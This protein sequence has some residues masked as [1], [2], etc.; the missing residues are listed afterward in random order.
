MATCIQTVTDDIIDG[1]FT[2]AANISIR[3]EVFGHKQHAF[4]CAMRLVF[5]SNF[6]R[7]SLTD[8][9]IYRRNRMA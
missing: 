2:D 6:R 5:G 7:G 9:E 1:M 4:P 8:A 3:H